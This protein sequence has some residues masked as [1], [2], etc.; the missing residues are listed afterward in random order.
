MTKRSLYARE[1]QLLI[2]ILLASRTNV[3]MTQVQL[4]EKS[5]LRQSDISRV[6]NGSRQVGYFEL[7]RWMAALNLDIAALDAE[8]NERLL[9]DGIVDPLKPK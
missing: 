6:E 2:S 4:A 3:G 7:R 5:G 1:N 8:L 9:R